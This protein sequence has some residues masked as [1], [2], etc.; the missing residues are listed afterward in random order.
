MAVQH[1]L[2]IGPG[3]KPRRQ[4]F[5]F[6][7][8]SKFSHLI[9]LHSFIVS[10][11]RDEVDSAAP[12]DVPRRPRTPSNDPQRPKTPSGEN[13]PKTPTRLNLTGDTRQKPFI[14]PP[15]SSHLPRKDY[16]MQ[17][18][19]RDYSL[20]N[21]K[22]LDFN[23]SDFSSRPPPGPR[24]DRDFTRD[25]P[26]GRTNYSMHGLPESRMDP[27]NRNEAARPGQFRSRTPGP[28]HMQQSRGPDFRPEP[29]RPKTPTASDMRSK[30]PVPGLYGQVPGGN[31]DYATNSRFTSGW[32]SSN[33]GPYRPGLDSNA[34][35]WGNRI[36][37]NSVTQN[38]QRRDMFDSFGRL[39]S[40][41]VHGGAGRPK[42]S[43]SFESE[44]PLPSNIT[45]IPKRPPFQNSTFSNP[46][47][48]MQSPL[49]YPGSLEDNAKFIEMN[50]TLLRQ[51]SGFGFRIIGGTEE[52][53]QVSWEQII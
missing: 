40:G 20:D 32:G 18:D 33:S 28:E 44:E 37:E 52:G 38:M 8:C 50:V 22:G 49:Q 11:V 39:N 14:N 43:T 19:S 3:R 1:G 29:S 24:N 6:E 15:N 41:S 23:R 48:G 46:M 5:S 10:T 53:S 35:T 31:P 26:R 30:T 42:Q 2:S 51:E 25:F 17:D 9:L 12:P 13:R 4:V 47:S 34:R 21:S 27:H 36:P 16:S 7:P 45:R